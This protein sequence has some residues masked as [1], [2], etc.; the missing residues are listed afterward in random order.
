MN[1]NR[2]AIFAE[3]TKIYMNKLPKRSSYTYK[4]HS[5]D[6]KAPD[7]SKTPTSDS[8]VPSAHSGIRAGSSWIN[9]DI[10]LQTLHHQAWVY[11]T[12]PSLGL[13]Q[14]D[15]FVGKAGKSHRVEADFC[16]AL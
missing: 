3:L 8:S 1:K 5:T 10:V 14:Q 9:K 15:L 11:F 4:K 6:L 7:E 12:P 2:R 13:T 16:S